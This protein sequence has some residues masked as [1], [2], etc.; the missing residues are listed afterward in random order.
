[1]E[2]ENKKV[3]KN[4]GENTKVKS[5]KVKSSKVKNKMNYKTAEQEEVRNFIIVIVV[6]LLCVGAIYLLTRAFV[7]KDLFGSKEDAVTEEVTPGVVNY[8][9]AIMGQLLN[10]PYKE[11][12]AVIYDSEG[13]YM[14]DMYSLVYS[15]TS[16]NEKAL[17]VY[18]IDLAN[19]LNDGYYDPENVNTKA[20]TLDE[21]KVGDI[22]L[23]K[24]KNG[25]I[26]KII[27]DYS[28]MQKELGIDE[29]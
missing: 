15:Y 28:K 13:D 21:L 2:K 26:S 18:T 10:R 19:T 11:Y 16:S 22:T 23:V 29:K 3:K 24:V 1:M 17:H 4:K 25:K 8:D 12:Y 6:V 5:S 9:V 20:K 27:V 14:Y 7:T